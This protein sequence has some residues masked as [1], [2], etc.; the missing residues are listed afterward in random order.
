MNGHLLALSLWIWSCLLLTTVDSKHSK[1]RRL[2][3]N[4]EKIDI[5][6]D[7][8]LNEFFLDFID[9]LA[10][11]DR[12]LSNS[13]SMSYNTACES[14]DDDET[15]A[16]GNACSRVAAALTRSKK[17]IDAN[18]KD[19]KKNPPVH[20]TNGDEEKYGPN[21]EF[22]FIGSFHKTLPH[23]ANG[24]VDVDAYETMVND[25]IAKVNVTACS[26]V[27]G[28]GDS[29]NSLGGNYLPAQ[30]I[31]PFALVLPPPPSVD[32]AE[33]AFMYA[34]VAWMAL[35]RDVPFSQYDNNELVQQAAASLSEFASRPDIDNR[36]WKRPVDQDGTINPMTQLFRLD[37]P[38][39]TDGPMV[40]QF[41]HETFEVDGIVVEPKITTIVPDSDTT[42][43][44]DEFLC[45]QNGGTDCVDA[46]ARDPIPRYI[47]NARDL[48][49]VAQNDR[50]TSIYTRAAN[51]EGIL[52]PD[53]SFYQD[54]DR[55]AGF[56][57][58]GLPDR[59]SVV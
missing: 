25:C 23:D 19:L 54:L 18:Y 36:M 38:G 27:P 5:R 2:R 51:I 21:S 13:M 31:P 6:Q 35:L 49:F 15:K 8:A 33:L 53:I 56:S 45:V 47:R 16:P 37:F 42:T 34:E 3:V 12:M 1:L 57:T 59:K 58:Q 55:Q 52:Q 17:I 10:V 9:S 28:M 46:P 48:G 39:V 44:F 50:V 14:A 32:S 43:T 24:L 41:L 40:S 22:P 29:A 26:Q 7:P 30:G 11:D 4:Q 20:V